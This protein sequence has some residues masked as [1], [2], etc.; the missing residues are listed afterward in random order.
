MNRCSRWIIFS[1]TI[2]AR[3]SP[4]SARGMSFKQLEAAERIEAASRIVPS[5]NLSACEENVRNGIND[6]PGLE[7]ECKNGFLKIICTTTTV[8]DGA[9]SARADPAYAFFDTNFRLFGVRDD[10]IQHNPVPSQNW[11]GIPI[12]GFRIWGYRTNRKDGVEI[13]CTDV[14]AFDTRLWKFDSAPS[15]S[16]GA[17]AAI[18]LRVW[19]HEHPSLEYRTINAYLEVDPGAPAHLNWAIAG[20]WKER[21]EKYYPHFKW[22]SCTIEA[23]AKRAGRV[24]KCISKAVASSF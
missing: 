15:I 13:L 9:P 22:A 12:N 17:A 23:G 10:E 11:Y 3:I 6:F 7:I 18:A 24:K 16:S 8:S 2:L 21:K 14:T 1:L 4:A 5:N 19:K 20:E